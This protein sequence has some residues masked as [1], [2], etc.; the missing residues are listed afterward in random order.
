MTLEQLTTTL[1][2]LC[3]ITN[4]PNNP[5]EALLQKKDFYL[6]IRSEGRKYAV[7]E[8][9]TNKTGSYSY[10]LG[11]GMHSKSAKELHQ[12]LCTII[13]FEMYMKRL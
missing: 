5:D 4:L 7:V 1:N 6:A 9:N 10:G 8:I 12:I 11:L 2:N 13:C 3:R